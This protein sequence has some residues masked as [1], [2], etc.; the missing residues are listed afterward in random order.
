MF[1]K[2]YNKALNYYETGIK[3]D[4]SFPSNYYWVTKLY[5]SSTE[6]VWGLIY[7]EIFMNL[8]RNSKR[9]AE[10]SKLLYNTYK[11]EIK[12]TSDTSITVSF[13]QQMT[14][15]VDA[16]ADPKNIKLPF[17]MIYEPTLL[18]S[19]DLGKTIDIN[20]LDQIRTRFV[21]NYFNNER[22]KVYPNVLFSYQKTVKDAGHIEAYNHW[23]LMKGDEEGFNKWKS[24]NTEKW[25]NFIKWFTENGIII[26]D[27]NKFYN[28]QY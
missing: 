9:T 17:C 22:D 25:D 20:S 21:D 28:G 4:P 6:E 11:N 26:N 27:T 7:G 15:N 14:M 12:F 3:N 18:M 24:E 10:I 2:E 16:L 1:I 19:I 23:I 13:C 8:E 5:C